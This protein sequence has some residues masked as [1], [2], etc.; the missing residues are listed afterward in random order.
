MRMIIGSFLVVASFSLLSCATQE[1]TEFTPKG[2]T[3]DE[4]DMSWNR[5]MGPEG[6][7]ALGILND[8]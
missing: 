5:P 7:G 8:R 2:P 4:S 1:K 3:S 6:A